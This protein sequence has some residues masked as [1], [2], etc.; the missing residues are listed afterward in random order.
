MK[1]PPPCTRGILQRRRSRLKSSQLGQPKARIC[2][3]FSPTSATKEQLGIF[4]SRG[5][6]L[7][8]WSRLGRSFLA[9][10]RA[11]FWL[12]FHGKIG[13]LDHDLK[14][15]RS[16]ELDKSRPPNLIPS[17]S[18][19]RLGE[20]GPSGENLQFLPSSGANLSALDPLISSRASSFA[21]H[22]ILETPAG[23]PRQPYLR[24]LPFPNL[25]PFRTEREHP[26]N[27][28]THERKFAVQFSSKRN[29]HYS[30]VTLLARLRG[31][32]IAQPRRRATW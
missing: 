3:S 11:P 4:R 18:E 16:C 21:K 19:M 15:S 13:V 31:W 30:T 14:A 22:A 24:A 20:T 5:S 6:L 28:R 25:P 2:S 29:S 27:L 23:C 9:P 32:S 12:P 7:G 8:L 1:S 17:Q 26:E 10:L